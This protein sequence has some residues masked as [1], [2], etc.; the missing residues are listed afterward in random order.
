[1]RFVK[2]NS[3]SHPENTKHSDNTH[4]DTALKSAVDT[5]CKEGSGKA[6]H[7]LKDVYKNIWEGAAKGVSFVLKK[8]READR[9]TTSAIVGGACALSMVLLFN[10]FFAFGYNAFLQGKEL[11]CVSDMKVANACI[12]EI[13]AEFAEY[14]S[15]EPFIDGKVTYAPVIAVKS[16]FVPRAELKENIK[17]TSYAMVKASSVVING[18]VRLA[19]ES[20]SEA[21]TALDTAL[22][23]YV[24]DDTDRAFFGEK[25]EIINQYVP[26]ALLMDSDSAA[27]RINAYTTVI[28]SDTVSYEQTVPFTEEIRNDDTMYQG[29]E[30]IIRKGSNGTNVVTENIERRDGEI[31]NREVVETNVATAPVM[32]LRV[33]GTK[34]RPP[35]VGTGSFIR[36]YYGTVS[37]R[38]GSRRSGTHSGVDFSGRTGDPI[39]AADAGKV[40]FAGW[41]GGYG[42]VVKIDHGNG[43]ITYYAHCKRLYVKE[44]DIVSKGKVIAAVGSTGNSTGPH[45]HFEIR[46]GDTALDPMKYVD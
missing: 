32:Q 16:R 25:V 46:Q 33:V 7:F 8:Y 45:L 4:R 43:Y 38:F 2:I 11:G 31:V 29:N 23:A 5:P 17:S 9:R 35:H 28:S 12:E 40:I 6:M 42:N 39:K 36:P 19:L 24:T 20:E 22:K 13:N 10:T 27:E 34:Y 21:N 1:M 3:D 15:G 14:M 26:S 44:G 18:K 41:S 30:K 37:S